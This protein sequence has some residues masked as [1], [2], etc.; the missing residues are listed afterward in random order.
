MM[1]VVLV[2][3]R[4][5]LSTGNGLPAKE[6]E[7]LDID[8]AL[9]ALEERMGLEA[10]EYI[11][12]ADRIEC[13]CIVRRFHFAAKVRS[14]RKTPDIQLVSLRSPE[15]CDEDCMKAVR[16]AMRRYGKLPVDGN[17]RLKP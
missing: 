1:A 15:L 3:N 11:G 14:M 7:G 8:S 17:E 2:G 12:Y 16:C 13:D 4:L 10:L 6:T 5:A 9:S